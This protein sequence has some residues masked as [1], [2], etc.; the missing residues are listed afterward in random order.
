M[1]ARI[2][3]LLMGMVLGGGGTAFAV[4]GGSTPNPVPRGYGV[5]FVGVPQVLCANKRISERM[6]GLPPGSI[7]VWCYTGFGARK[8][9]YSVTFDWNWIR[10]FA[11]NGRQT[12][13]APMVTHR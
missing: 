13:R 3:M 4:T 9:A 12:Y 1:T 2:A 11:P 8:A 10:V 5:K 6:V 7:G